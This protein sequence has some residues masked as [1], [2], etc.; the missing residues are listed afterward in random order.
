M[1][2]DKKTLAGRLRF[3]LPE[4]IGKVHCGVAADPKMLAAVLR[5]CASAS[6]RK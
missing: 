2:A 1:Q 6:L 3:V 4:K 5:A